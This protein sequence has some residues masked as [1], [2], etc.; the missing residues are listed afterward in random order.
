[1]RTHNEHYQKYHNQRY[2][3]SK[4][5]GIEFNLSFE[6]WLDWW[7]DDIE[8]RGCTAGKL[9]M[10]RYNDEGPY[11]L[12]NIYKCTIEENL[13]LRKGRKYKSHV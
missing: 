10:G 8:N 4:V 13:S 7:G 3:A 1:M 11:A 6:E 2:H 9:Q 5:R 12:G